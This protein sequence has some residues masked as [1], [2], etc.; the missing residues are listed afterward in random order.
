[1]YEQDDYEP[2]CENLPEGVQ[3]VSAGTTL[4]TWNLKKGY[5]RISAESSNLIECSNK[6]ACVGGDTVGDYCAP[7]YEGPCK[8]NA[9]C[10]RCA[11]H[12]V[13]QCG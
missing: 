3:A 8:R 9:C 7:G 1:M 11:C 13:T 12:S 5:Y 4:A 10:H 2:V 6:G